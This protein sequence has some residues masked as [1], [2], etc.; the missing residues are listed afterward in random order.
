MPFGR[1]EIAMA[2]SLHQLSPAK[3]RARDRRRRVSLG[4]QEGKSN[5]AIA[6]ELEVD[7]GTVRRDLKGMG[8]AGKR[9]AQAC[10]PQAR[11]VKSRARA[12]C[13]KGQKVDAHSSPSQPTKPTKSLKG[14]LAPWWPNLA[15]R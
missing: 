1:K 3:R 14:L 11:S 13:C 2:I 6:H 4:V 7:E 9:R 10:H 5:R 12:G 8:I 15:V